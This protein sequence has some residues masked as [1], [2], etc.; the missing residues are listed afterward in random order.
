MSII[1]LEDRY[2]I[3]ALIELYGHLIDD[4]QF[5]RLGEIFTADAAFDLSGYGGARYQSLPSI[6]KL[7]SNS[8]E[9]PLAHHATNI[10]IHDVQVAHV[11]VKSKGIGVGYQG[12]VGS[13]VYLDTVIRISDQWKISE[14]LVELRSKSSKETQL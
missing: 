12:R 2:A 5:T 3:H 14:R 10:V 9:H 6:V 1:S 13:V 11:K 4:R 7:M 8:T